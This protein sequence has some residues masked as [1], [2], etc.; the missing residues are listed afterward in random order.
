MHHR[1]N[2]LS[3]LLLSV[4]MV[5]GTASARQILHIR[6]TQEET[7]TRGM[8]NKCHLPSRDDQVCPADYNRARGSLPLSIAESLVGRK[9]TSHLC[10]APSTKPRAF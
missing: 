4:F 7:R 5:L 1:L 2:I 10:S 8:S 6:Q 9:L 3:I